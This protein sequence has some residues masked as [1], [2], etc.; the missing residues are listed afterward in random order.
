MNKKTEA[1][2]ARNGKT[3]P[4]TFSII[5]PVL[6]EADIIY[7]ALDALLLQTDESFEIIVVDG[8]P[9][10]DTIQAIT[11][12]NVTVLCSEQGRA[13]QMN[14]GATAAVGDI[15]V[16]LHAD[17]TLPQ[18]ALQNIRKAL[19]NERY[20]G[21]AF[22]LRINSQKKAIKLLGHMIS[23]RSRLSRVPFGDQAIFLRR[24]YF[25][26]IG[27]YKDIV[28][29]EDLELMHRIKKRGEKICLI[30]DYVTTSPRR[31]ETEGIL[32]C[33]VRNSTLRLLYRLGVPPS[34]L[35]KFYSH[36]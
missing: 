1:D 31:W 20:V 29:M 24:D 26:K 36:G 3:H 4:C 30:T 13:R 33:T 35:A 14:T 18:H 21:C 5:I 11:Q 27:G 6:H 25:K 28:L 16:F 32:R 23:L 34:T 15:L 10:T 19:Q 17:T 7:A 12:N 9:N 22:H 2:K 8:S